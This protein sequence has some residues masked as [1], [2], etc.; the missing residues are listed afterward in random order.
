MADDYIDNTETLIYGP[1]L[2]SAVNRALEGPLADAPAE[3]RAFVR[4]S[5]AQVG[6]ATEA[7]TAAMRDRAS[8]TH[9]Q[10][11]QADVSA[12]ARDGA[13]RAIRGLYKH[14]DA[15]VEN[16]TWTGDPTRFLPGGLRSVP[17]GGRALLAM[18]D[19]VRV[20]L[21]GDDTVPAQ[22]EFLRRLDA[23][24]RTLASEVPTGESRNAD[25]RDG[26]SE[27]AAVKLAWLRAYR[28]ASLAIEAALA[29]VE[30]S[31][32][33]PQLVPHLAASSSPAPKAPASPEDAPK[34]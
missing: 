20:Q 6:S 30:R 15:S 10:Q 33:L 13:R 17:R 21:R 9:A 5:V 34:P 18:L 16:E 12:S 8:S 32:L 23:A 7:M 14:L 27:Q 22:R 1:K 19:A 29:F 2:V 3:V 28:A 11:D 25:A 31:D 24:H 4:W 26:L